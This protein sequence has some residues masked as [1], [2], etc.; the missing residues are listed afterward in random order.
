MFQYL[1]D[2]IIRE[3]GVR[4]LTCVFSLLACRLTVTSEWILWPWK[5]KRENL[6]YCCSGIC[7][8][9]HFSF[10]IVFPSLSFFLPSFLPLN[11]SFHLSFIYKELKQQRRRQIRKRHLTVKWRWFKLYRA[12][13]IL[14]NSSNGSKFL[15]SWILK[16]C[17]DFY[18]GFRL[19]V[20]FSL[21]AACRLFSRRVIFTRARVSHALLSLRKNGGL[22]VVYR[23]FNKSRSLAVCTVAC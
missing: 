3:F 14:F 7:S 1:A 2:A 5:N 11:F 8:T 20:V 19:R 9:E 18:R 13:S 4:H 21:A 23:G 6:H 16:N 10:F 12:Y 17:I 22:L 15:W